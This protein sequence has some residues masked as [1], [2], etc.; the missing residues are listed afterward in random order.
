MSVTLR[1]VALLSLAAL[2]SALCTSP[3]LCPARPMQRGDAIKVDFSTAG[4]AV[5]GGVLTIGE[6]GGDSAF[7]PGRILV[8]GSIGASTGT[9]DTGYT[10]VRAFDEVAIRVGGHLRQMG[11]HDDLGEPG[12]S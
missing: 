3:I 2:A 10:G 11:H 7:R 1:F 12:Q 8:T 5:N 6:S 4:D 9:L